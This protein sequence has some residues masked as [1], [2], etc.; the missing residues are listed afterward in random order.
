MIV[1]YGLGLLLLGMAYASPAGLGPQLFLLVSGVGVLAYGE[2]NRRNGEGEL[3]LRAE[4]LFAEDGTLIA[5]TEQFVK[6]DRGAFAVKPSNGFTL[7]LKD[8]QPRGWAPGLWWRLGRRVGVGGIASAG[9]TKFM[10]EQIAL[11]LEMQT[12]DAA[13]D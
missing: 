11:R 6:V 3:T 7:I 5:P 8:K 9:A 4:G 12:R 13:T 10:A 2:W 1:L